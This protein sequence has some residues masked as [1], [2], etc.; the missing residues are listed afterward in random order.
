M[1]YSTPYYSTH[2]NCTNK[3]QGHIERWIA[4]QIHYIKITIVGIE[5]CYSNLIDNK[6][7]FLFACIINLFIC[8]F[9]NCL[10]IAVIKCEYQM[11]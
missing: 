1:A 6:W 9:N 3:I 10:L 11:K 7:Y 2:H 4:S 8:Y 5:N